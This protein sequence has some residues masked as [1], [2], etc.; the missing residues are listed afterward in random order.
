VIILEAEAGGKQKQVLSCKE[1]TIA[2]NDDCSMKRY[3]A[4]PPFLVFKLLAPSS[5]Q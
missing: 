3:A 2:T 4:I 5:S 1:A